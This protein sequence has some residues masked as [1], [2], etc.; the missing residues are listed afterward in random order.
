M[1]L[2][3]DRRALIQAKTVL[4]DVIV[5]LLAAPCLPVSS[6]RAEQCN[7]QPAHCAEVVQV[8]PPRSSAGEDSSE[9][10]VAMLCLAAATAATSV[11]G[12]AASVALAG[13]GLSWTA[14]TSTSAATRALSSDRQGVAARAVNTSAQVGTA[15]GVAVL[16]ALAASVGD[17]S[18]GTGYIAAFLAASALA[19][20]Y[21]ILLLLRRGDP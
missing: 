7:G 14:I 5:H 17:E 15:L 6:S 20:A 2:R 4:R 12:L 1:S 21:A 13:L 18:R 19:G 9:R 3:F 11:T 8:E 16:L 10:S